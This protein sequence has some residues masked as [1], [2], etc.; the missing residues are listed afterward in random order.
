MT[1]ETIY[2]G[3]VAKSTKQDDEQK[4]VKPE[5]PIN[6]PED[7]ESGGSNTAPFTIVGGAAILVIGA[8]SVPVAIG[9]CVVVGIVW[10]LENH[11]VVEEFGETIIESLTTAFS[12]SSSD[13]KVIKDFDEHPENWEKTKTRSET[14]KTYKGGTSVEETYKN[15]QTG[16][17]VEVHRIYGKNGN[18]QHDHIRVK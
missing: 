15:K 1:G 17:E 5:F 10:A 13:R 3:E 16:Q 6:E 9:I 2:V 11:D 18:L 4:P 14:S 7:E 8:T 12:K